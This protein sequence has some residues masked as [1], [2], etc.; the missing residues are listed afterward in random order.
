MSGPE[1][2]TTLLERH[3]HIYL[4]VSLDLKHSV[5]LSPLSF[6]NKKGII[7]NFVAVMNDGVDYVGRLRL[8]SR[9]TFKHAFHICV[10]CNALFKFVC[11]F[12]SLVSYYSVSSRVVSHLCHTCV[13]DRLFSHICLLFVHITCVLLFSSAV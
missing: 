7:K 8:Y 3:V 4:G 11:L 9:D 10:I 1:R 6:S 13:T 5:D 12:N 2:N